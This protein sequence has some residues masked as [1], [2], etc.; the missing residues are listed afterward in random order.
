MEIFLKKN[1]F[2]LQLEKTKL[3]T[4]LSQ[5]IPPNATLSLAYGFR[6]IFFL[7]SVYL[8]APKCIFSFTMVG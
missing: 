2:A 8:S 4:A 6:D 3:L 7:N 5:R 1:Y